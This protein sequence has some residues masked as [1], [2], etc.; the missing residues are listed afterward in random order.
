[1]KHVHKAVKAVACALAIATLIVACVS[2]DDPAPFVPIE[3]GTGLT[4]PPG[5]YDRCRLIDRRFVTNV[6]ARVYDSGAGAG[7]AQ[8]VCVSLR[9]TVPAAGDGVVAFCVAGALD[10]ISLPKIQPVSSSIDTC[11][12]CAYVQTSCTDAGAGAVACAT[13]YAAVTGVVRILR[14]GRAV[15]EPVW[16][17]LGNLEVARI[18]DGTTNLERRDC[19]FADSL[20]LQGILTAGDSSTCVG[21]DE[22]AC[23]I[24]TT[25]AT[26][27]P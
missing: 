13:S 2:I 15:G 8:T 7:D 21:S 6:D 22:P 18:N 5:P 25:A 17:D 14:L 23:R 4:P 19:L 11:A 9:T 10:E 12:Y 3:A 20:T 26:R 1:M 27:T 16:I 24:A